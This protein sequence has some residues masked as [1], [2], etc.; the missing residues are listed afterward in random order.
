MS[1]GIKLLL[2]IKLAKLSL[3]Y[4]GS[5]LYI[6]GFDHDAS[7]SHELVLTYELYLLHKDANVLISVLICVGS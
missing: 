4:L 6:Y 3:M 7:S 2:L 5:L 1:M